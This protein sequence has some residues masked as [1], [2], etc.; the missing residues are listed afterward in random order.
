VST[1]AFDSGKT[2]K[3]SIE[4]EDADDFLLLHDGKVNGFAGG[5]TRM[6]ENNLLGALDGGL[7]DREN[8]IR[9]PQPDIERGLG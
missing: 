9:D 8:L 4:G 6:A 5:K 1:K 2:I 3:A 7:V